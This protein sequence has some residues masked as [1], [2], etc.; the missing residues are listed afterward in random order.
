MKVIVADREGNI[1]LATTAFAVT[2]T[3]NG[4]S[5]WVHTTAPTYMGLECR[6]VN[7]SGGRG[8]TAITARCTEWVEAGMLSAKERWRTCATLDGIDKG[9]EALAGYVWLGWVLERGWGTGR[10][11]GG[12]ERRKGGRRWG[13]SWIR[14]TIVTW[15][16]HEGSK[17]PIKSNGDLEQSLIV[18]RE[19]ADSFCTA[20]PIRELGVR[21]AWESE[22]SCTGEGDMPNRTIGVRMSERFERI[23]RVAGKYEAWEIRDGMRSGE[24]INRDIRNVD[25]QD[26]LNNFDFDEEIEGTSTRISELGVAGGLFSARSGFWTTKATFI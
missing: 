5:R 26:F 11:G 3:N 17:T 23:V 8:D 16:S 9:I 19:D 2:L 6:V 15:G 18:W 4:T 7:G 22:H 12:G 14:W 20:C 24:G 1:A 25:T 21:P 10:G 13:V